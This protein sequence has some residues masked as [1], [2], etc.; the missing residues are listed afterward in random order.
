MQHNQ[1]LLSYYPRDNSKF[2]DPLFI[3]YQRKLVEIDGSKNGQVCKHEIN[4]WKKNGS[5]SMVHSGHIRKGL[6]M[7]FLRVHPSDPCPGGWTDVGDGF[8]SRTHQQAHESN[9]YTDKQFAVKHQYHDGYSISQ[10]DQISKIKLNNY[11]LKN[12]ETFL[13]RSVNPHSGEYV[14]YHESKFH[15]RSSKYGIVPSRHSYLGK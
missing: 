12:S 10:R 3:P 4:T 15:P 7:D 8:C 6:N 11:D 14:V 13:N 5:S 1:P 9:F 2:I